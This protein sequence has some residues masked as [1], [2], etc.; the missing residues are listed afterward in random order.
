MKA[1]AV[2]IGAGISGASIAWHLAKKGMKN[3]KVVDASYLTSGAT[4]RCG[5]GV[6]TQWGTKTNCLLAKKSMEFFEKAGDLLDYKEDIEFK[7]AGYLILA[8]TKEE[9]AIFDKNVKVQQAIGIPS[10]RLTVQEALHIVPHLNPESFLSA[11]FCEKDGHLNPFR[12]TD[13]FYQAAKRLGVEFFFYE[14]VTDIKMSDAAIEAVI[15]DRR[16]IETDVVIDAAGGHAKEVAAMAGIDVPVF[17]E[18]HEILATEPTHPMQDPMIMSFSKNIYCQQVPHGSF[19]M[20]RS[21]PHAKHNH[22]VTSSWQF[23]EK[24]AKTACDILPNVGKLRVVRQ[25]AGLYN[26]SPDRQPIISSIDE[27]PGFY[28]ACGF[29]GHGFM[30]SPITGDL[31]SDLILGRDPVVNEEALSIK[32]FD[33]TNDGDYETSVV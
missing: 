13:A 31:I 28:V 2:I 20:G 22:D 9:E 21:N 11:S 19:L 8:T 14:P 15:T 10:K 30:F 3:I 4:G 23:L 33:E 27:L 12:M 1:D 29:S 16:I 26:N 17:S 6:R 24:M 18:K 5:A 7:Q 32:R 25:W